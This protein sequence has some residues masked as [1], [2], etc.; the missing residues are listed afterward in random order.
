MCEYTEAVTLVL[1]TDSERVC[2]R[3]R[4]REEEKKIRDEKNTKLNVRVGLLSWGCCTRVVT[5]GGGGSRPAII[6]FRFSVSC[7]TRK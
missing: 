5:V 3:A 6:I 2:E 7:P 4:E 1:Q